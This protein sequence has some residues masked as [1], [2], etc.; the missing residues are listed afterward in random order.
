MHLLKGLVLV[1]EAGNLRE[2][3]SAKGARSCIIEQLICLKIVTNFAV[4]CL[5]LSF[6]VVAVQNKTTGE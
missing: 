2:F 3:V 6:V 1:P 4:F 5:L